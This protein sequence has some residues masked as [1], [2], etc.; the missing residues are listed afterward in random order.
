MITK[1]K[2]QPIQQ[3]P[4]VKEDVKP[5]LEENKSNTNIQQETIN[6]EQK[7]EEYQGSSGLVLG[8]QF[9]DTINQICEMGFPKEEAIRALRAAFNNPERAIE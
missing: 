8:N 4:E 9:D 3:K 7:K 2:K 1:P 5:E 6:N